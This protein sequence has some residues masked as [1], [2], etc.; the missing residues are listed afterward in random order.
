MVPARSGTR[1]PVGAETVKMRALAVVALVVGVAGCNV[2]GFGSASVVGNPVSLVTVLPGTVYAYIDATNDDPSREDNEYVYK[3]RDRKEL[4][5]VLDGSRYD[6]RKDPRFRSS[7]DLLNQQVEN[8]L[9][10]IL[11]IRIRNPESIPTGQEGVYEEGKSPDSESA[12][13]GWVTR[14]VPAAVEV[15]EVKDHPSTVATY[16]DRHI[17]KITFDE[18]DFSPGK[19][20]SGVLKYTFERTDSNPND[21]VTGTLT[22]NFSAPVI[23]ELI[24]ECSAQGDCDRWGL[25]EQTP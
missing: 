17:L 23:R 25:D 24:G 13:W 15:P 3:L 5:L 7:Q 4:V 10:G 1:A 9:N 22:L 18:T 14:F 8:G 19:T 12:P 20:V 21:A 11:R 6:P 2:G 16:G